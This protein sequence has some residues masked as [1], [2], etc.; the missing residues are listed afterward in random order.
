MNRT[1]TPKIFETLDKVFTPH[2]SKARG[3]KYVDMTPQG[4]GYAISGQTLS[5]KAFIGICDYLKVK[6]SDFFKQIESKSS[7]SFSVNESDPPGYGLKEKI[8]MLEEMLDDKRKQIKLMEDQLKN[9][10]TTY[11]TKKH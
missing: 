11:S 6:P 10:P 2:G 4:L 3:A 1:V 8:K 5:L 9:P 7:I